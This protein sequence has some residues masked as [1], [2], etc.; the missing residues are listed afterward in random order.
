MSNFQYTR[1][2]NSVIRDEK[3]S[4]YEK[5]FYYVLMTYAPCH[6]PYKRLEELA[7]V[8]SS[9]ISKAIKKLSG[10]LFNYKR[11]REGLNN[12]YEVIPQPGNF[13]KVPN[14]FIRRTDLNVYEK[15]LLILI[16][17]YRQPVRLS[18]TR[19]AR[20]LGVVPR[21]IQNLIKSPKI[22]PFLKI[23]QHGGG[24]LA[25]TYRVDL[26]PP[27]NM[28]KIEGERAEVAAEQGIKSTEVPGGFIPENA[29]ESNNTIINKDSLNEYQNNN[30]DNN[31]NSIGFE[32]QS[33]GEDYLLENQSKL[34]SEEQ[35]ELGFMKNQ[36]Q[37]SFVSPIL[38]PLIESNKQKK[39]ELIKTTI[40]IIDGNGM[41]VEEAG[42]NVFSLIKGL[43]FSKEERKD[44]YDYF[45]KPLLLEFVETYRGQCLES[46]L[47][48]NLQEHLHFYPRFH[49]GFEILNRLCRDFY[50]LVARCDS[51]FGK[52]LRIYSPQFRKLRLA[53][54]F[55]WIKLD[56][57]EDIVE[58][59]KQI[60]SE[61]QVLS[62]S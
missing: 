44:F 16:A 22:S 51:P 32:E 61:N 38:L 46:S 56:V 35:R 9:I 5:T 26:L 7:G 60:E 15:S 33:F 17:S 54:K 20:E 43:E 11:G 34:L 39:F 10:V 12:Q 62:Y 47:F 6:P 58:M 27:E 13:L 8:S 29:T 55:H 2:A 42:G 3:L 30:Y 57:L 45:V 19:I 50:D 1:I 52:P 4:V 25:N 49:D 14:K 59:E 41:S 21:T 36:Y 31:N 48:E 28:E 23:E 40:S 37:Q 53:Y 24:K 18:K